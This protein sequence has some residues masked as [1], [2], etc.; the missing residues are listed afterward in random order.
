MRDGSP[1]CVDH[2]DP[3]VVVVVDEEEEDGDEDGNTPLLL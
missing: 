2:G 1:D 3:V